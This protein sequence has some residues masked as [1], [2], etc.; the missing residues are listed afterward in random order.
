MKIDSMRRLQRDAELGDAVAQFNLG[1][2]YGNRSGEP[3]HAVEDRRMDAI[4]WLLRSANQGLPRAQNRLA[5]IY[6]EGPDAS[7]DAVKACAWF[8]LA[9]AGELGAR[10][11]TARSGYERAAALLSATQIAQ[12]HRRAARW[13]PKIEAENAQADAP[14]LA[15]VLP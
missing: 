12:A 13:K 11:Q 15:T 2:V 9:A 1:I 8:L 14:I 5:E 3:G 4:R 10:G 6:V 7:K